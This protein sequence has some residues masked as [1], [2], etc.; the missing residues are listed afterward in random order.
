MQQEPLD[1]RR[2]VARGLVADTSRHTDQLEAVAALG[3]AGGQLVGPLLDQHG[4]LLEQ[5]RQQLERDGIVGDEGDRLDH[6]LELG[7]LLVVTGEG[8]VGHGGHPS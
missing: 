5:L 4:G 6:P 1:V 8:F 7:D 3:I 2:E